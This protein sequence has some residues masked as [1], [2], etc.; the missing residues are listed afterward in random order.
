VGEYY[1]LQGTR[2]KNPPI[3]N[4]ADEKKKYG[5]REFEIFTDGDRV[6]L[7]AWRTP[8]AVYWVSNTILQTL[9]RKQ[10]LSIARTARRFE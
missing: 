9:S 7:V 3:L 6:R 10:M 4:G 1:G 8:Q 2:W 5:N